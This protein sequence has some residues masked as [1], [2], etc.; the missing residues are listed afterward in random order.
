[1]ECALRHKSL[2]LAILLGCLFL[3]GCGDKVEVDT[4]ADN[5]EFS[6]VGGIA[7]LYYL[8]RSRNRGQA[9]TLDQLK[10]FGNEE[11]YTIERLKVDNVDE[12]LVSNRDKQPVVLLLDGK[13]LA[14]EGERIIAHEATGVDGS[15][16][17]ALFSGGA[18]LL[19]DEEFKAAKK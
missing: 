1:M 2:L 8:Y 15:R 19:T 13:K 5:P 18:V 6:H 3:T 14:H 12:L 16:M 10:Q 7:Q 9:P 17:V 4:S 11:T